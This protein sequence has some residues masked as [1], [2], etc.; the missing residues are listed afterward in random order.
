MN[1]DFVGSGYNG[2][3]DASPETTKLLVALLI[4]LILVLAYITMPYWLEPVKRLH[5]CVVG[6]GYME[7]RKGEGYMEL[8]KSEGCCGNKK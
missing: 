1:T 7:L 5:K 6:E 8:R 3:I 4:A 2:G